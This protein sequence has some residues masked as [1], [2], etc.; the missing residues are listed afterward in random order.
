MSN[1]TTSI[2]FEFVKTEFIALLLSGDGNKIKSKRGVIRSRVIRATKSKAIS[3]LDHH[4]DLSSSIISCS[5]ISNA[6]H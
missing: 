6:R 1:H 4:V 2:A 3:V 5:E